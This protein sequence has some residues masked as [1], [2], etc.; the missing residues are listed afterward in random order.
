[1]KWYNKNKIRVID[2]GKREMRVEEILEES[3]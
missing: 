3:W 2:G 1:M